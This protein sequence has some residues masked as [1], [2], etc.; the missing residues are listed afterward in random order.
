[1]TPAD[2]DEGPRVLAFTGMPGAGKSLAVETA[3]ERDLPVVRMGDAIWAEVKHRG[4]DFNEENVGRV[5][6]EMRKSHGPGI[7]AERTLE[8]IE[9]S[10]A[11]VVVIDGV[12]TLEEIDTLRSALGDEFTLVAVH[13]SP[14]TRRERLLERGREDD[15]VTEEGFRARDKRE[16]SWGLGR[17]IA[18]A[19]IMIVNE[20][21]ATA[22]R[23]KV[24]RLLESPDPSP[25]DVLP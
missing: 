4:L 20:S 1:M 25:T 24:E 6:T 18:L 3:R 15:V 7:W 19:D 21:T 5:A 10:N 23:R 9:D 2:E 11:E 12:R 14:E 22:F 17:A 8:R 16:L 13:A